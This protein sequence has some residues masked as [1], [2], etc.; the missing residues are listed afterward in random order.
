MYARIKEGKHEYEKVSI[1]KI[2]KEVADEFQD[3][4][5]SKKAVITID[6][7]CNSKVIVFQFRQ[8]IHNLISNALKFT[9]SKR[10]PR[11]TIKCEVTPGRLLKFAGLL[12]KVNYCHISVTDNG[13]GFDPKYK[14]RIFEVFQRLHAQHIYSGTGMG[15][16]ICKRIVEN[17]K[18]IIVS[19]AGINRGATF[20]I[21]LPAI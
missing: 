18:G 2:V 21:Y 8:V 7:L 14:D 16:A 6:G 12:P 4:A 13:I 5:K 3:F 17:H 11:I 10:F 9:H 1:S 15:L 19:N 20:D